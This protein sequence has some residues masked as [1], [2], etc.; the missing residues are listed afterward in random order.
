MNGWMGKTLRVNLTSGSIVTENLDKQRAIA[1]IGGR[2]LGIK[3]LL[4]EINP[5]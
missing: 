1:F 4:D 5:N 2:G 3:Y